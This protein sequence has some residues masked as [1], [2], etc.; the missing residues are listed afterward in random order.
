M[1]ADFRS[2][3]QAKEFVTE[4]A[5]ELL[6]PATVEHLRDVRCGS[7]V[8]GDAAFSI[9]GNRCALRPCEE[10]RRCLDHVT[11]IRLPRD[12]YVETGGCWR[13]RDVQRLRRIECE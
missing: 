3:D 13:D 5:S 6:R 10:V 2:V 4:N 9:G 12:G 7:V 8:V 11:C 1:F